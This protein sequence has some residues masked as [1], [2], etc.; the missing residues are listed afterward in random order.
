MTTDIMNTGNDP[1]LRAIAAQPYPLLFAT[2]SG[3][4]LYGF[5]SPDSDSIDLRGVHVLPAE[6]VV[7][8][9]EGRST[10]EV[11]ELRPD[12]ELDLV[13]HDVKKFFGLLL[14]RNGYVLEQL[15]SP[16]VVH[17]TPE[18]AELKEDRACGCV[19]RHHQAPLPRLRRDAVG[20]VRQGEPAPREAAPLRLSRPADGH[21]PHADRRDAVEPRH[22][23]R[24]V[25]AAAA[26]RPHRSQGRR[27]GEGHP[28]GGG[29]SVSRG[30]STCVSSPCSKR[31]PPRS[32]LP[33]APSSKPALHDL[34]VRIRLRGL[35]Q[36]ARV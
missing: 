33:E 5:P 8:F 16:L 4:H 12:L 14:N 22:A 29:W 7:G 1:R 32:S 21:S 18:H 9:E 10:I 20:A 27:A 26:R 15:H 25:S 3:A 13:T 35:S 2:V 36:A 30:G 11:A 28:P 19:T 6:E 17:T 31:A 24:G 23:Q 34:L